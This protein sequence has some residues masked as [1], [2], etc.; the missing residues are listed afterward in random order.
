MTF[1][2]SA[3]FVL[4]AASIALVPIAASAQPEH[5]VSFD[6]VFSLR[7]GEGGIYTNRN[8]F[9]LEL[10]G[11]LPLRQTSA[12]TFVG[13]LTTGAQSPVWKKPPCLIDRDGYCAPP[14]PGMIFIGGLWG[15]ERGSRSSGSARAVAGPF[16]YSMF[17]GGLKGVGVQGRLDL[18]TRARGRVA[19]VASLRQA[20]FPSV[21]GEVLGVTSVGAGVRIHR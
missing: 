9:T 1:V 13:G 19:L 3:I 16:Y 5:G 17:L 18:A 21:R 11:M 20:V 4:A 10:T 12:G 14:F 6:A 8:G 2:R 7:T 15:I